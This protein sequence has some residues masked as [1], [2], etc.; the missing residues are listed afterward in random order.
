VAFRSAVASS[1]TIGIG[2]ADLCTPHAYA[3]RQ[4]GYNSDF[5]RKCHRLSLFSRNSST[6]RAPS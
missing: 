6:L 3:F 4:F 5:I 2:C 1:E